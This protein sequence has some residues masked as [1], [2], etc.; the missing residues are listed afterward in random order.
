MYG[1][2]SVGVG[3]DSEVRSH[4]GLELMAILLQSPQL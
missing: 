4:S 2:V 3:V 1:G